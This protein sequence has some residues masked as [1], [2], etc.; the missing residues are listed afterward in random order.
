[1]SRED[2]A[3]LRNLA[4][5]TIAAHIEQLIREGREI[6]IDRLVDPGKRKEIERVF[7]SI[8]GWD[9]NPVIEHFNGAVSYEEARAW[10]LRKTA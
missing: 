1:M 3:K 4:P 7:S 5:S 8:G 10:M 2:I 9:L 6:D